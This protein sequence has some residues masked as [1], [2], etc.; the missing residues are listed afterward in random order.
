MAAAATLTRRLGIK[1]NPGHSAAS[2]PGPVAR[3]FSSLCPHHAHPAPARAMSWAG[4]WA[5]IVVK[6]HAAPAAVTPSF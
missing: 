6:N 3:F 4:P 1:Y 2:G 5:V